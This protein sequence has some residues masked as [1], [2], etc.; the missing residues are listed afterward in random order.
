M[1]SYKLNNIQVT[2]ENN[3]HTVGKWP[4]CIGSEYFSVHKV[5]EDDDGISV[6]QFCRDQ[7]LGSLGVFLECTYFHKDDEVKDGFLWKEVNN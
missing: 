6:K 4:I 3:Y 2:K 5:M 7:K 1:L